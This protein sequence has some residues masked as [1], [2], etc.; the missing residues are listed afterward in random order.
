VKSGK[1]KYLEELPEPLIEYY[2]E[3]DKQHN[4][5]LQAN[6]IVAKNITTDG[7]LNQIE[8]LALKINEIL[9]SLLDNLEIQLIDFRLEFGSKEGEIVLGD[10][11]TPEN[12]RL[13][14]VYSKTMIDKKEYIKP[15]T[16]R[17]HFERVHVQTCGKIIVA[18]EQHIEESEFFKKLL[19]QV[20]PNIIAAEK[21]IEVIGEIFR[22]I[23]ETLVRGGK[24]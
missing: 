24:G 18:A 5:P 9:I 12:C 13:L 8:I 10:V 20:K 19:Q 23:D 4:N 7:E 15:E 17:D 1:H 14:D 2:P 3:N 6:D 11:I 21:G 16:N 22:R